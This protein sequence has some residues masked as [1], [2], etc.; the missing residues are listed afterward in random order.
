MAQ[1]Q[2][3][4]ELLS[5]QSADT[6]RQAPGAVTTPSLHGGQLGLRWIRQTG[7]WNVLRIGIYLHEALHL[8]HVDLPVLRPS[9][10]LYFAT[11]LKALL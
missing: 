11:A 4:I 8:T 2:G 3:A 10:I 5:I 9:T 6:L 7:P 1:S